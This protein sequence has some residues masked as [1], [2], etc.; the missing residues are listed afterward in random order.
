METTELKQYLKDLYELHCQWYSYGNILSKYDSEADKREA[1]QNDNS[2]EAVYKKLE[3]KEL[4]SNTG[5]EYEI[6]DFYNYKR[7]LERK[8]DSSYY[9][10]SSGK[11]GDFLSNAGDILIKIGIWLPIIAV[12]FTFFTSG[13]G[14]AFTTALVGLLFLAICVGIA[15][16]LMA[17]DDSIMKK[18]K[19][20]RLPVIIDEEIKKANEYNNQMIKKAIELHDSM[21]SPYNEVVHLLGHVYE[22]NIVHPKYR[23][24]VA[25]S[26]IYEY[27]DTGRC[28]ELEG[29]DG[30]YNLYESE[31]RQD[32]IIEQLD[33]IITQLDRL[34]NTMGYV[35]S[36]INQSNNLLNNISNSLYR[37]EANT[38]LTAYNTQCIA[39]NTKIANRYGYT[40]Q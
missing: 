16:L 13:L 34:N 22:K 20:N 9:N 26:Q 39:N 8:A 17:I 30:A 2:L 25:I 3:G 27:I 33:V 19:E 29:P 31:L 6:K 11:L 36:A 14:N 28:T 18:N 23:N 1:L 4:N 10:G 37:I 7:A 15:N 21:V 32:R 38:A 5:Y 24:L 35:A 12:I 40:Y